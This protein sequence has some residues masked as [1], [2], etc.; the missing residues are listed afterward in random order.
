VTDFFGINTNP[1]R[2]PKGRGGFR[3]IQDQDFFGVDGNPDVD[4]GSSST[5]PEPTPQAQVAKA[6]FAGASEAPSDTSRIPSVAETM[7]R[8]ALGV[9]KAVR[10]GEAGFG[11]G[12]ADA[13]AALPGFFAELPATAP[14]SVLATL[15]AA[16]KAPTAGSIPEA[17]D[18][19]ALH[20]MQRVRGAIQGVTKPVTDPIHQF[21]E[22]GAN[23]LYGAP[24]GS[25][26]AVG[27]LAGEITGQLAG[28]SLP[29][30]FGAMAGKAAGLVKDLGESGRLG[31]PAAKLAA[32][33]GRTN[34]GFLETTE[35]ARRL[36]D[37]PVDEVPGLASQDMTTSQH[38]VELPGGEKGKVIVR[39]GD[40]LFT[41]RVTPEHKAAMTS[42]LA[43][44]IAEDVR[45]GL[46]DP[47]IA[48]GA[49][50]YRG[51]IKEMEANLQ[52]VYPELQ[53]PNKMSYAKLLIA[54]TSPNNAP[55]PNLRQ[56]MDIYSRYR[57]GINGG[58]PSAVAAGV[59]GT[60]SSKEIDDKVKSLEMVRQIFTQEAGG[61]PDKGLADLM[62]WLQQ[63]G[64]ARKGRA[65]M[66]I[67]NDLLGRKT[68]N[69]WMNLM[70][71]DQH[72][73]ADVWAIRN[74]R[75]HWGYAV[76][77][78]R[79]VPDGKGGFITD[80]KRLTLDGAPTDP[81]YD[82][83]EDAYRQAAQKLT[84]ETGQPL[85]PMDVQA[86][87]WYREKK[88]YE[89]A[90]AI[91]SGLD[92]FG[93]AARAY[94][95]N[96]TE[97]LDP[98]A[99][100]LALRDIGTP[101]GRMVRPR[102]V[103]QMDDAEALRRVNASRN[104]DL[105]GFFDAEE[106]TDPQVARQMLLKSEKGE[107]GSEGVSGAAMLSGLSAG[108]AAGSTAGGLIGGQVGDTPEERR[109]NALV[110]AGLGAVAGTVASPVLAKG[111][112]ALLSRASSALGGE[113]SVVSLVD[114]ISEPGGATLT[115]D[116]ENFAG[117]G[118]AVAD[119]ALTAKVRSPEEISAFL[120]RP[121]VK[122]A[123]A[124]G[125]H[126]GKWTD[127]ETGETEVNVSDIMS[128]Q[129]A[130]LGLGRFRGEKAIGHLV[131]GE[132]QGD[133]PVPGR[134]A[135]PLAPEVVD[136]ATE[137][138]NAAAARSQFK[139]VR[140]EAGGLGAPSADELTARVARLRERLKTANGEHADQIQGDIAAYENMIATKQGTLGNE[141]GALGSAVA[142]DIK[143]VLVPAARGAE[144]GKAA[145]VIRAN[146]GEMAAR[147]ERAREALKGFRDQL[148]SLPEADRFQ[149]IDDM[150]NGRPVAP[151]LQPAADGI[152]TALDEARDQIRALGTGKLDQ[153]IADYFPH[154]WED[155][156]QAQQTIINQIIGKRPLAGPG[157]FLK[158]RSIPTI[159][160]GIAAGLKPV[161][162]NP[163]D[164]T[165]LKLREMNRY[166][167][168]QR[169]IAEY[170][171]EG[172]A[173]FV[174]AG[175]KPPLGMK[176][177]DDRVATVYAPRTSEGALAIR[178]SYYA[179]EPVAKVINNYLSPGLRGRP[180]YDA[181][182]GVGNTLNQAQLGLSAFHLG[183]T[184]IDAA[185]SKV[186]LGLY[187]L[188]HG[189]VPSTLAAPAV[190][191]ALGALVG[192]GTD[193]EHP[194]EG[195]ARG[196][197]LGAGAGLAVSSFRNALQ[198][199][200]LLAEYL[201][202]GSQGGEFADLA[203]AITQAGGRVRMDTFYKNNSVENFMKA[204]KERRPGAAV[205]HG[206]GSIFET[207]A[208]PVLEYVV[209]RQK[210][211]VFADLA[212]F[213][214][215]RLGANA[216]KDEVRTAMARAW[217]SVDNRLG[218]L[219]YDNLFWN[220]T[221][222][223][224]SMASVRAVGWN[225]GS[226]RELG[227]GAMDLARL[228]RTP[229]ASYVVALPITVGLLGAVTQYLYTGKGP[230]SLKDYFFP[231]TGEVDADGNEDRVELPSYMKDVASFSKHPVETIEHKTH[232]VLNAIINMLHNED[233][234]GDMIRNPDDKLVQ[235]AK[236][237]AEYLAKQ[238]LPFGVRNLQEQ[239]QRGQ[240]VVT[241]ALPFV[242]VTPAKR[243]DVRSPAQN[244]M[245][246]LISRR[247]PD[248]RTPE[249]V[250][251]AGQIRDLRQGVR[252]GQVSEDSVD[253][254]VQNRTITPRQ[255]HN[256]LRAA[257]TEPLAAKFKMLSLD[258]AE[259]VFAKANAHEKE[260]WAPI[261][262]DKRQRALRELQRA[263]VETDD[264]FSTE[265]PADTSS[266]TTAI[267]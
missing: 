59:S 185:V 129:T 134:Q 184:S 3:A 267:F 199:N 113:K 48:N 35:V 117:T 107:A 2:P 136:R 174:R 190:G 250:Q 236:Q 149:F 137:D 197:V 62:E 58:E 155:P 169:V 233:Y 226:I 97:V 248:T 141:K 209:P 261:L 237:E 262:D 177:I 181:Y 247:M 6:V 167:F 205:V 229:K 17:L 130:A 65:P 263:G 249:E 82:A 147:N 182:M 187:K 118:F 230:E 200:K 204:L 189:R 20:A 43:D 146:S 19:P 186:A 133:I 74:A 139:V 104:A 224:L 87:T 131:N 253:A 232:P 260:L 170:K 225:L 47:E 206:I 106:V 116:G 69:F 125:K 128:D 163:V 44:G 143:S 68:S 216:T 183:F 70:G 53:D 198:G 34:K 7:G 234:Y 49:G 164:L 123:L 240:D 64:P 148:Q 25:Q 56:A 54:M 102:Q 171:S 55:E 151:E 195:A 101:Y 86:I 242:G 176:A 244:E 188:S 13:L 33:F 259:R 127:P 18:V 84:Q 172:L 38:V 180:L 31:A 194:V 88:L 109:R 73:T 16:A 258:E 41:T 243:S 60:L 119:P 154:I 178:G 165:L 235:Q 100:D 99:G 52:Q 23:T 175:S 91:P 50:W 28:G 46:A 158:Q 4:G 120:A 5:A 81:E 153:F 8:Q 265:S 214:I 83:I 211:G 32:A 251:Q 92:D 142:D 11:V 42:R 217:D 72:V 26:E 210:L 39:P 223:D 45:A 238:F 245:Q 173:K 122:E 77:E 80:P 264:F 228:R 124:N 40:N 227:G 37:H 63:P 168:G 14:L 192:A 93:S 156:Q 201:R 27:R 21:L 95:E 231:R 220:K 266:A 94:R 24:Q 15:Q 145:R 12:A 221:L 159:A 132:Y 76:L 96:P 1:P 241:Q 75:R 22:T 126:L 98:S 114:R 121:D 191:S 202:P 239:R 67:V 90:G 162:D 215:E 10:Q 36:L 140:G 51:S 103:S 203:D 222:K 135:T 213:E 105:R 112:E 166:L 79:R 85:S 89:H 179:P 110:G 108:P 66:P 193:R 218:Q 257:D 219:V 255:G 111:A 212:R 115:R 71:N 138:A 254:L 144:A 61:D 252:Q 208:K 9:G 150:E 246:E 161:S 152:R 78:G 256:V 207:A 160:D 30:P 57:L 29:I 157:N 196:A